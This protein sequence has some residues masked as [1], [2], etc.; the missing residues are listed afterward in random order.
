M[1]AFMQHFQR[2]SKVIGSFLIL[3]ISQLIAEGIKTLVQNDTFNW[4]ITLGLLIA[5]AII[6]FA[7]EYIQNKRINTG[8]NTH[9]IAIRSSKFISDYYRQI[10]G[11]AIKGLW[12]KKE[13][14][15]IKTVHSLSRHLLLIGEYNVRYKMGHLIYKYSKNNLYRMSALID[16][17][18][19][20]AVLMG[21]KKS[22]YYIKKAIEMGTFNISKPKDNYEV[23]LYNQNYNS[24]HQ[25]FLAARAFRHIASTGF[26]ELIERKELS[27]KGLA[28]CDYL[29][30]KIDKLPKEISL[31]KIETMKA[32][33]DYG[34]GVI[35]LNCFKENDVKDYHERVTNLMNA[36]AYNHLSKVV[37]FKN[38]DM[39]RYVKCLLIENEIYDAMASQIIITEEIKKFANDRTDC[40][41][42]TELSSKTYADNLNTVEDVLNHSIYIDE[43][44]EIFLQEKLKIKVN[45]NE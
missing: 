38:D 8:K 6:L 1:R 26:V 18:G 34:L 2:S 42:M 40:Q 19:W 31:K 14:D 43:A 23:N 25:L 30:K 5:A 41:G 22:V 3:A 32:G 29:L 12:G 11:Y 17:I 45:Q 35:Y 37:A 27:L 20:T 7:V 4:L 36:Y 44:Y 21:R 16:E 15:I 24:Y 33:I 13:E 9:S 39:H 28:I 10:K